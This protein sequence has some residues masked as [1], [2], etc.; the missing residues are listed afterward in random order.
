MVPPEKRLGSK[1]MFPGTFGKKIQIDVNHFPVTF[2]S[3][4]VT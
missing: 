3:K 1:P 2:K 4:K